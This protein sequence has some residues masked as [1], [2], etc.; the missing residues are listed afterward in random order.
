VVFRCGA[1]RWVGSHLAV[2]PALGSLTDAQAIELSAARYRRCDQPGARFRRLFLIECQQTIH[3]LRRT[4][5]EVLYRFEREGQVGAG[6]VDRRRADFQQEFDEGSV[7]SR[8]LRDR[9]EDLV[10]STG[11]GPGVQ[12][13][14]RIT[15]G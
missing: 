7:L 10:A 4:V 14:D 11:L 3:H 12:D 13:R 9:F 1:F 6:R 5:E 8:P 2:P 15:L